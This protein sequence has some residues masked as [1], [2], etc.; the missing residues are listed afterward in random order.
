MS[1]IHVVLG[2]SGGTGGAVVRALAV[3]G[4]RVRAVNRS[5]DADVPEAVERA[6]ADATRLEDLRR[7]LHEAEVVYHCAQPRYTRWTEEFPAMNRAIVEATAEVGAKLVFADNLYMYGPVEGPLSEESPLRPASRKG[8]LRKRLA[9]EL[10][11]AHRDGRIRMTISRA[12]DYFGPRAP[13][14]AIGERLFEAALKDKR[15]PVARQP[16][17]VAHRELRARS[18]PCDRDP[19]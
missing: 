13:T 17:R 18:G 1:E 4:H 12:S 3:R 2:A 14:S 15:G 6:A 8:A 7:V 5:G 16:R 11:A 10:L 9:D 19:R